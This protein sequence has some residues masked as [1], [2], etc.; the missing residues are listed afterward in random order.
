[1]FLKVMFYI[2]YNGAILFWHFLVVF[3]QKIGVFM[4]FIAFFDEA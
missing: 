1:M 2:F 4:V 3:H